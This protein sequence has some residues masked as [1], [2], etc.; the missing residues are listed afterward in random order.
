[1][2]NK[3]MIYKDNLINNIKQ[4]KNENPSSKI[5]AMVKANAYGVGEVEV[6]QIL[7]DFVDFWGVACFF[8]ANKIKKLTPKKILIFG[9]VEKD[10]V[11]DDFSYSC[12]SFDDV[13]F[14]SSLNRNINIHLKINSGMN[15]YGF[16]DIKEFKKTLEFISK[17][18]LTLEG[19]YTHFATT[20]EFVKKQMNVFKKYVQITNK[21]GFHPMIHADNSFVNEKYN[22]NLDMVRIGFS[23]YARSDGWFLPA[24]EIKSQV[25]KIQNVKKGELIGY[26]YRCVAKKDTK[27]AIIPVGYADGFD[28][29]FIGIK[30]KHN[31]QDCEVLNICMD[32][33]ML[34][35][36]DLE[37]KEGDE[38][39]LV[40]KFNSV[41]LYADHVETTPYEIL[42]KFSNMRA[43]RE[44][45]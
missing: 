18:K 5:C 14:F 43:V 1:M 45:V 38:L 42:T 8:E 30:L 11:D 26:N 22:H 4:V 9:A 20:N 27:V 19:V 28:M 25:V 6:V 17:S 24:Y 44:I 41:N 37:I 15:R 36:T 21:L 16:K 40:N 39:F 34:D 7:D 32:C 23:V 31:G 13:K 12:G 10:C 33:F 3:I 29:R 2:F 35:V